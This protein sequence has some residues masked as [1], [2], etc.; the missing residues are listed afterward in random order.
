MTGDVKFAFHI[1]VYINQ[2]KK[3]IN[4]KIVK[5]TKLL[6]DMYQNIIICLLKILT[7]IVF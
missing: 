1:Q 2:E 3:N 5:L 7:C 4:L 6:S